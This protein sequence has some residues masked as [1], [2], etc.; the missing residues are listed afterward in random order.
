MPILTVP[1]GPDGPILSLQV[2]ISEPRRRAMEADDL[3]AP[4]NQTAL[5]L[6]DTGASHT[7]VDPSIIR[8]LEI[9]PLGIAYMHSAST[10]EKP[11]QRYQFDLSLWVPVDGPSLHPLARAMSVMECV[12]QFH[13]FHGLLGRDILD[14]CRMEYIGPSRQVVLS[15]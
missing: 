1:I 4:A 5:L 2:G 9:Q 12:F 13:G 6:I 8:A 15:F 14:K 10:G 7:C 11:E 3:V